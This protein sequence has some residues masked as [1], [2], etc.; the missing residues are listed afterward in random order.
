MNKCF[1]SISEAMSFLQVRRMVVI[2]ASM[3][4][5]NLAK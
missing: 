1:A 3:M 5:I 4:L 2:L